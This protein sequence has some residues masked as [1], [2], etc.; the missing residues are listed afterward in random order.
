MSKELTMARLRKVNILAGIL[1]LTQMAAVLALSSDFALPVTATYMS[2]PPGSSFAPAVILFSTPVG[3]TV[4]IFLGLSALFHFIVASPQFFGRYS[5]GLSAQR[6]YFRWV[7]YSI[8][9]SVM[10]VLIAQVTG[11]ADITALISIFG[12]N[13]SMILFG[14]LQEKYETP[15]NGGWL[16]FIFGCITG[17]VPWIALAFYVLSI[18]GV[19]DTTAPAFVY[20]IVFTIFIFFNSFA[21]VQWVQYKKV[22][23]W[24]DYLRGERTYITLSL[25]AKS[26]LAWQIFANTLIPLP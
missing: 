17:I 11:I 4:A 25:V 14:W 23:K 26:A 21:L 9:S 20:G 1:H 16:P 3:L 15:G 12:V 8:S 22:G 2:G 13:A 18:G 10:I 24:S 7:E 6:N 19:S 5:A